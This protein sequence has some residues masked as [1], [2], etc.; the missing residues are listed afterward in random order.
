M[1]IKQEIID[2][3]GSTVLVVD[4]NPNNL[5]VAGNLLKEE[6]YQLQFALSGEKALEAVKESPPDLVLLDINMPGMDGFEVCRR[7]HQIPVAEIIPVIFLT[8]AYK[9]KNSITR[10]F[11]AGGVDYITKP[12]YTDELKARIKT[13]IQLKKYRDYLEVLSFTDPLTTLHNR[14]SLME[15]LRQ[16]DERTRR[17]GENYTLIMS[18]IDFFKAVNDTQGHDCGDMILQEIARI[19]KGILREQDGL[20]RWGGEEFLFFLPGTDQKGARVLAEKLR[21]RIAETSFPW[22]GE[23]LRVTMTFGVASCQ[24]CRD[25]EECISRADKALYQGKEAGRN[26]TILY[27]GEG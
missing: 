24:G 14:R 5:Q 12:F 11:E 16:Q 26:Q 6:P 21:N 3:A 10:G 17:S 13:H 22:K 15:I 1:G 7:I 19:M 2:I 8:A 4:D 23:S 18:D 27:S 20:A 9:D 25:H